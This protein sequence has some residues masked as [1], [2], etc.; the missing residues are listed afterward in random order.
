MKNMENT[1]NNS[2]KIGRQEIHRYGKLI[3]TC[4]VADLPSN[5]ANGVLQRYDTLE[6]LEEH[7]SWCEPLVPINESIHRREE[8]GVEVNMRLTPEEMSSLTKIRSMRD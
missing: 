8:G 5:V 4:Y 6:Q 2:A 1:D 3:R 7:V